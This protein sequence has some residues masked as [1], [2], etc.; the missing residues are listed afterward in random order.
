M[1]ASYLIIDSSTESS[2]ENIQNSLQKTR[3]SVEPDYSEG[4]NSKNLIKHNH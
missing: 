3:N 4:S 1:F 2:S